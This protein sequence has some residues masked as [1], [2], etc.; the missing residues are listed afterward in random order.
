[1]SR[2]DKAPEGGKFR[3]RLAAAA[4]GTAGAWGVGDLLNVTV[5]ASGE[6]DV[7]SA[8]DVDGVILTSE[9]QDADAAANKDTIGGRV[10]T[11]FRQCEVV[12]VSDFAAPALAA[13]DKVYAAA[14]GDV[15]VTPG[16]GA[17]FIGW[18]LDS[19]DRMVIDVHG[20]PTG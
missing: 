14:S 15:T 13:G 6:L 1:M 11:V 3:A 16:A 5:D 9:G 7:A 10:Y 18:V 12:E 4:D 19:G 17:I 20:K 2:I 8:T